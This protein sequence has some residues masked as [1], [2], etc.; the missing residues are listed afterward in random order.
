MEQGCWPHQAPGAQ[1]YSYL[2]ALPHSLLPP[3]L[4]AKA[5]AIAS[6]QLAEQ[7]SFISSS[8]GL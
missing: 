3:V 4:L 8:P 6:A 7:L 2:T 1:T 5:K